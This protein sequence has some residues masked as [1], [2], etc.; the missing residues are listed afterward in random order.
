[1]HRLL[2]WTHTLETSVNKC[3]VIPYSDTTIWSYCRECYCILHGCIKG[4]ARAV[5]VIRTAPEGGTFVP[6]DTFYAPMHTIS[7]LWNGRECCTQ[8]TALGTGSRAVFYVQHQSLPCYNYYIKRL[9]T[10]VSTHYMCEA[11]H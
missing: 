2:P 3:F 11:V 5:F 6:C 7:Y 4:T 1:M 8:N 10:L 9:F